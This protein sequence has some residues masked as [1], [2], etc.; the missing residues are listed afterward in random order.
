MQQE[1]S[2]RSVDIIA[3]RMK[4]MDIIH[5][6][7]V[8]YDEK[9]RLQTNSKGVRFSQ[10][11]RRI[12][13]QDQDEFLTEAEKALALIMR[14]PVIGDIY[15]CMASRIWTGS[16]SGGYCSNSYCSCCHRQYTSPDDPDLGCFV[17]AVVLKHRL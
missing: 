8:N 16:P 5:Q 17:P 10:E 6:R 14:M 13:D 12:H 9:R 15:T 1:D 3:C 11:L 7:P 4:T 2:L